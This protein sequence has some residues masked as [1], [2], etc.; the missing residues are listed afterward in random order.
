MSSRLRFI[1]LVFVMAGIGLA[2]A[3]IAHRVDTLGVQLKESQADRTSLRAEVDEQEQA[4]QKYL[5]QMEALAEQVER[6]GGE[7]VVDPADPTAP[8]VALGP[9]DA[10][11]LGAIKVICA[12]ERSPCSPTKAQI[13]AALTAICGGSCRGKD[14]DPPADGQDGQDA[15]AAQIDAAVA[16]HCGEDGCRGPGPTDQQLDDRLA[17]YCADGR[18]KGEDAVI[19]PSGMDCPEGE[20]VNGVHLL[21]DGSLTVSCAPLVGRE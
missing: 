12:G 21:A 11:V 16:R 20:R 13:T 7:P 4:A 10:Q 14:A 2:I 19:V 1:A 17:A 5:E 6:L 8:P 3:L 18:C 9:T 15:T